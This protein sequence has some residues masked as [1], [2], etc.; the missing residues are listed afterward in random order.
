MDSST[1]VVDGGVE[2]SIETPQRARQGPAIVSESEAQDSKIGKKDSETDMGS[3]DSNAKSKKRSI[4]ETKEKAKVEPSARIIKKEVIVKSYGFGGPDDVCDI[5]FLKEDQND[6]PFIQCIT[7]KLLVHQDCYAPETVLE[8]GRFTCDAC[9]AIKKG[10]PP[11]DT[12]PRKKRRGRNVKQPISP[13]PLPPDIEAVSDGRLIVSIEGL[14][15]FC[16]LCLRRDVLGGMKAAENGKWVHLSCSMSTVDVYRKD[17]I[18]AG[19]TAALKKSQTQVK[20]TERCGITV[21]CEACGL[22]GGFLVPCAH[23]ASRKSKQLA[24]PRCYKYTHP[25]CAEI[26][27][28]ERVIKTSSNGDTILFKCAMHSFESDKCVLCNQADRQNQMLVC[29]GCERGYHMGCLYP[30]LNKVPDGDWFCDACKRTNKCPEVIDVDDS[31]DEEESNEKP[32]KQNKDE[33]AAGLSTAMEVDDDKEGN[34]EKS[35]IE[36]NKENESTDIEGKEGNDKGGEDAKDKVKGNNEVKD[37]NEKV[38]NETK[39]KKDEEDNGTNEKNERNEKGDGETREKIDKVENKVN[40]KTEKGDSETREKIDKVEN[41]IDEK[42]EKGDSE[43]REKIDKVENKVNEKTEKGDTHTNDAS[44]KD[45]ETNEKANVE[46]KGKIN[47]GENET[48]EGN[49]KGEGEVEGK[50]EK[51]ENESK[52]EIKKDAETKGLTV[53]ETIETTGKERI[54]EKTLDLEEDSKNATESND[55]NERKTEVANHVNDGQGVPNKEKEV[56]K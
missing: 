51:V 28:R 49:D 15:I 18:M 33:E 32:P 24:E 8:D 22:P 55:L 34:S 12:S 35:N 10:K 46:R 16:E 31:N 43:T 17:N 6:T 14:D 19:V 7:C 1:K 45:A 41:K 26:T 36:T 25:L 23:K 47:T 29:D 50:T 48:K 56:G 27:E 38:C 3:C 4:A 5:C 13:G 2:K 30:P 42:T 11:E 40:E 37:T 53:D 52:V 20:Y 9:I 44:R 39:K 54:K 21:C